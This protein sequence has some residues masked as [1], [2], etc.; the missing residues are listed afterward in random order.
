MSVDVTVN[1][2]LQSVTSCRMSQKIP[3]IMRRQRTSMNRVIQEQTDGGVDEPMTEARNQTRKWGVGKGSGS[4]MQVHTPV[5]QYENSMRGFSS[6]SS[7]AI[8]FHPDAGR[9]RLAEK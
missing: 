5:G 6:Q 1:E 4:R 7:R 3:P 9:R 8:A 2:H